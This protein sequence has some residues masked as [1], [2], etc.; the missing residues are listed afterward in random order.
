VTTVAGVPG[1]EGHRDG[2]AGQAQFN[3]PY[4]VA[5]D[6]SGSLLVADQLNHCVRVGTGL[7]L[8]PLVA[9]APLAEGPAPQQEP[10]PE[11]HRIPE[12]VTPIPSPL[13]QLCTMGHARD[14]A[15]AALAA[16]DGDLAQAG[17]ALLRAALQRRQQETQTVM[18]GAL[19][20]EKARADAAVAAAMREEQVAA[21]AAAARAESEALLATVE[22]RALPA[23]RGSANAEAEPEPDSEPGSEPDLYARELCALR[24][25]AL[26]QRAKALGATA[27]QIDDI[28]DAEDSKSAAVALVVSLKAGLSALRLKELKQQLRAAGVGAESVDDLDDSDDPKATAIEMLLQVSAGAVPA[29]AAIGSAP[30]QSLAAAGADAVVESHGQTAQVTK[31]SDEF[32]FVFS[33]RTASDALCLRIRAQLTAQGLRVWQQKTNIPKDSDNWFNEW[34]PSAVKSRKI[35]CFL[36]VEYLKSPYCMK[37][38]GIA[39]ASHKLL[40]V[41]C[42]PLAQIRAVDPSA[43]PYA[44]NALAYL[45]GGGQVVFHDTEDVVTEILKFA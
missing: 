33:N 28:D 15:R 5:V 34:F 8:A 25:K 39:L 7:G 24:L 9:A 27:E 19:R 10:E 13:Q 3:C 14:E 18:E 42:E 2:A 26:K 20:Q 37:E 12:A 31:P 45:M 16:Y 23:S 11:P 32:E 36:T 1:T 29:A 35:V 4:G 38:F 40:V 44:S 17:Q 41:A 43:Y 30:P 22:H 21:G 6:G